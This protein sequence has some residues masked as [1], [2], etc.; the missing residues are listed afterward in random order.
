VILVIDLDTLDKTLIKASPKDLARI[1]WQS[2]QYNPVLRSIALLHATFLTTTDENSLVEIVRDVATIGNHIPYTEA[3][4]CCQ[5]LD[6]VAHL[7]RQ[8]A[9]SGQIQLAQKLVNIAIQ[10]GEISAEQIMDGDYWEMSLG[11]LR[12]LSADLSKRP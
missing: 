10:H 12:E 9:E 11:D 8:K 2:A 7:I 3:D 5:V 4:S 6:E 1:I